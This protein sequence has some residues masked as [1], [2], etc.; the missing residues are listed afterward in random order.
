MLRAEQRLARSDRWLARAESR[1]REA[2]ERGLREG[3]AGHPA[4]GARYARAGLR[5][6]G[7][8]E[9]GTLP[10][11]QQVH[12]AH[13][14]LAARLMGILAGFES[15]Q[16]R[17][18]SGLRLLDRADDLAAAQDRGVLL[19]QR[20]LLYMW[21]WRSEDALRVLDDAVAALEGNLAEATNLATA[22]LNRSVVS[23][24]AGQVR[25]A[26][27]DL[28]RCR[29]IAAAEGDDLILAKALHNLGYCV[30]LAGDIP[31][32]LR[33]FSETA[34]A[35]QLSAPGNLP[36]LAMDKARALLA[37]G[38]AGDAA[39]E[40][41][42]AMASFRRQRLDHDLAEAELARSE[43]ALAAGD[44]AA[45]RSWAAT[46]RR[47]FRRQSNE[48]CACL[49]ELIRLRAQPSGRARIQLATATEAT[50]LAERLRA[51][52]LAND[53]DVAELI[54]ARALI[55]AGGEAEA[56]QRITAVRTSGPARPLTVSLLR[57]LA[58]AE[59]AERDGQPGKALAELRAGLTTV[60][61]RRGRLGSID[62]QT[63]TAAL[64]VELAAAGLRLALDQKSAPLIFAWLERSRA[65]AFRVRP[66]L[67]PADP[68]AAS[69]LAELRQ[70]GYLIRTAEL[71][72]SRDQTAIARHARLQRE[73]REHG[74]QAGRPD[75]A[76]AQ[77]SLGEVSAALEQNG[78]SLVS[79]LARR[80]RTL[81]VVVRRRSVR[82][83]ELG[84]FEAAAEAARRL[85][86]DL[87]TL[88]G[89]RLPP[90]LEA[91]V[92]ESIRHQADILTAE[93][94]T[95]LRS[96][97][98]DD[99]I[100]FVPA[101]QLASIPWSVLPDLRGRP[102]TVCPSASAWLAARRRG[103]ARQ[104]LAGQG[105]AGQGL[106]GQGLAGDGPA[107]DGSGAGPPLLVAGPDLEHATAEV[108]Q[109]AK[110]Y[111]DC[112][113]LLPEAATVSATLT[114]L[115]GVPLAHL[116]AHGHHDGE[117]V[118]FSRLDLADGPLMAYDIQQLTTA[119]RHV[120]LSSCDV[121][122]TVIRPG[123][124]VLG[125]TAALLYIG[126]ATVISSVARV[127][128]AAAVAMMTGYHRRLATGANPAE[129]LAEAALDEQFS[130]FVCFGG[131]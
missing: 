35:Y 113:L 14:A 28:V 95:P 26:R 114:A 77:A 25:R 117:N 55:T 80:G 41:D 54:A 53:A 19:L 31:A 23:L 96:A 16:G 56:R 69:A 47:H 48:A 115:T 50:L 122:R 63:G 59:I 58:T 123:E 94:I 68:Q 103:Q 84:D 75:G 33:L 44:L 46:A 73:I 66:V 70:L 22:L 85:N 5:Q 124:E 90:R 76:A 36:V 6:L 108:T 30:L 3:N 87:D 82:V 101:G 121:G 1:A 51:C 78:L 86:A 107:G 91:V 39:S 7:W 57:R 34:E 61:A 81:A 24:N 32:A 128:D 43:A 13:H 88:A 93:I 92:R 129:A 104:G 79:I 65:Q 27:A 125:F 71:K 110:L 89:R 105:L 9:E 126:T 98:G 37:A 21:T 111:P 18:E 74:W 72:G 8:A 29:R 99:G 131:G 38:L 2:R 119:P 97:L 11:T 116:A 40:L 62:L 64:G 52:G 49:A 100:V 102:V 17:T 130:P 120:V 83:I 4:V 127:A 67:P 45:A 112:R 20:G 106:A 10:D 12:D 109:I 118:L 42:A 15:M 60:Q